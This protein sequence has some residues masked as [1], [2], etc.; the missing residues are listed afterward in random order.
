LVRR[1]EA[2]ALPPWQN[3]QDFA[4]LI[5][6]LQRTLPLRLPSEI[7][8][9]TLKR[10]VEVTGGITVAI[11][12]LIGMLAIAAIENGEERITLGAVVDKHNMQA[13]LGEAV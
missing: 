6:T 11:F 1:F 5:G 4:G 3:D 13:L 10:L 8:D 12:S 2:F 7:T 9:A